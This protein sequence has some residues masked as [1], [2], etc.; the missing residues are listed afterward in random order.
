MK[1]FLQTIYR[2]FDRRLIIFFSA[3]F[4][5]IHIP[6]I[7][8]IP[9]Y[10]KFQ[11][12]ESAESYIL[13]LLSIVIG[14]S[15]FILTI[16]LVVY[17]TLSKKIRRNS[18]D[19]IFDNKWIK[20]TFTLFCGSL[21]F[22]S[23]AV[24]TINI[25]SINTII[26]L[27]YFSSFITFINL[28]L[29]FPLIILCIKHSSSYSTI[30]DLINKVEKRD[31][32][33][34]YD[35]YNCSDD[36]YV[37]ENLE[38]NRII[39]LKDIGVSAIKDNDWGLPQTI[40]NDLYK[41][42]ISS[43][44]KETEDKIVFHNVYTYNF[45]SRHFKKVAI[46]ESDEITIN[47]LLN[48]LINTHLHFAKHEI[49]VIRNNPIDENI[50]DLYRLIIDNNSFYNLQPYLLNKVSKIIS[51]HIKSTKY[52]DEEISTSDYRFQNKKLNTHFE[53]QVLDHYWF[54]LKNQLPDILF[55]T[56]EYAIEKNNKNVYSNFD[57]HIQSLLSTISNS[58]SLT[59]HQQNDI[60]DQYS[61]K[62]RRITDFA[63]E[64]GIFRDIIFYSNSQIEDWIINNKK[65]G[66]SA[67][68]DFSYLLTKLNSRNHL[69]KDYI[70]DYFM[71]ARSISSK[72]IDPEI[73]LKVIRVIIEDCF[74]ILENDKSENYVKD[75]IT[76]Q[77]KW[78]NDYLEREEDLNE[79]RGEFSIKIESLQANSSYI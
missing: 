36:T 39:Q 34:L 28:L 5:F 32:E 17:N 12:I 33:N 35:P 2:L 49:R 71:I 13:R 64:K 61:Y 59:Q 22:I 56:L 16:L 26:T 65:Y 23:S 37:I 40:L 15:S 63:M 38:K 52:S 21:I 47:V 29:Q 4:L 46:E 75:E 41:K 6:E 1:D 58:E 8:I 53:I 10:F 11:K 78:L 57:W 77:L 68:Y 48:N 62:A 7:Q 42:L 14:F 54:Y 31:I 27:L 20:F 72:K 69:Y 24:L 18:F 74:K 43:L 73:K 19:F 50:I 9:D 45:I 55:K 51:E 3:L 44:S 79:L 66:F 60:F 67:L 76:R 70:D 30:K 25:S